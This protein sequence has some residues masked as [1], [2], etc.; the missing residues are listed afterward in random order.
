MKLE[1]S[2]KTLSL[3]VAITALSNTTQAYAMYDDAEAVKRVSSI[4][5]SIGTKDVTDTIKQSQYENDGKVSVV[6]V[7]E[8]ILEDARNSC[9]GSL[10]CAVALSVN[11]LA[12]TTPKFTSFGLDQEQVGEYALSISGSQDKARML[13]VAENKGN[14]AYVD[15]LVGNFSKAK[16]T[17]MKLRGNEAEKRIAESV[18][19]VHLGKYSAAVMNP[20]ADESMRV[21]VEGLTM[22][23]EAQA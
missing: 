13:F 21:M 4:E 2:K 23:T 10:R 22:L 6:Q 14:T 9:V 1:L 11:N 15:E 16:A 12:V 5:K 8:S 20:H 7:L 18:Q 3:L 17:Q 19:I